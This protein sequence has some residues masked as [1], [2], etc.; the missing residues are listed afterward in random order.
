MRTRQALAMILMAAIPLGAAYGQEAAESA[1]DNP[2]AGQGALV[3]VS[4]AK[5][6]DGYTPA[7]GLENWRHEHDLSGYKPGTYNIIVR[8]RDSAGNTA[9]AGP[10]NI[11]IDPASDLPLTRIAHPMPSMRIGADLNIVGTSKD[12]DAIQYVELSLDDGPWQKAEGGEYW[13]YYLSTATMEDG[14]HALSARAVDANGALGPADLVR[15]HLD[16]TKPAATVGSPPF[17]TLVSGRLALGGEL[18]DANGLGSLAYSLDDGE[19]WKALK[20]SLDKAKTAA[21]FSLAIDTAKMEDGPAVLW[22]KSVDK[23]GSEGVSIFLFF[24][25]NTRPELSILS[26]LPS[27]TVN[28]RF[29]VTGRAYDTVGL[30]SLSWAYGKE[31]GQVE[32]VPG[33]PYFSVDFTAPAQGGK[34]S[35]RFIAEDISGNRSVLDQAYAIDAKADIPRLS[36]AR[37]L[38]NDRIEGALRVHGAARDDDGIAAIEW[39]LDG[40]TVTGIESDGA[41]S[42]TV[43]ELP[44]GKRTLSLRAVDSNGLAGPWLDL[45]LFS[46]A[47]APRLEFAALSDSAGERAFAPG[48]SFSTLEGRASLSARVTAPNTLESLSFAVNDG[49]YLPLKAAKAASPAAI[50]IPLPAS[51]PF[52]VLT[53]RLKAVDAAGK[54][55]VLEAPLYAVNYAKVRIGPTLDF[56]GAEPG[57]PKPIAIGAGRPFVGAFLRPFEGEDIAALSLEPPSALLSASFEGALVRIEAAGEGLSEPTTV[58]VKTTRGHRFSAGPY[59][60]A[61][62][63]L[64]PRLAVLEPAFNSWQRGDFTLKAEASDGDAL[65]RVEYRLQ[66]GPWLA[67]ERSGAA[68][69]A[70]LSVGDAQGP[71]LIELRAVDRAGNE[72]AAASAVMV[73]SVAPKP[74]LILPMAGEPRGGMRLF[75]LRPGEPALSVAGIEL[76]RAGSYEPLAY[77]PVISFA[78]DAGEG[79]LTLRVTDKAGNRAELDLALALAE[80]S[81]LAAQPAA[82]APGEDKLAPAIEL[83]SPQGPQSGPFLLIARVSDAGG[84]ASVSYS[85]GGESGEFERYEGSAYVARLFSFPPKAKVLALTLQAVDGAGNKSQLKL[86]FAYD[87]A[88]DSPVVRVLSPEAGLAVKGGQPFIVYAHDDDELASLS[89]ALD[90]KDYQA[91]GSGPLFMLQPDALAPGKKSAALSAK[92]L[93]GVEA[94]RV[95]VDFTQLGDAPALAISGIQAGKSPLVP[96][97]PGLALA[98]D[99]GTLL[100]GS[101]RAPNGLALLEYAVNGS[102]WQKLNAAA[103]PDSNGAQA[104]GIPLAVSLPFDRVEIALRARDALGAE[105]GERIA[106]Y[107]LAAPRALPGIDAEGLYIADSRVKADGSLLLKPQE[108]LGL[109]WNGRPIAS[110]R[111]EPAW[112]GLE[113]SH[114]GGAISV[115]AL[116][117]GLSPPLTIT[118]STEDGEVYRASPLR[119]FIDAEEPSIRIA[120]PQGAPWLRESLDI[121]GEA[122]DS[123]GLAELA[124]SLDGGLSW[125][126]LDTQAQ[127]GSSMA[128]FKATLPLSGAD[129]PGEL[130]LRARDSAGREGYAAL[131]FVKDTIAPALSLLS[132]LAGE[133][134]NGIIHMSGWAED[135]SELSGV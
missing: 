118:L 69:S 103:K 76:G 122:G 95:S 107:R 68:Y 80:G 19:S 92:D 110:A 126:P 94:A 36:I 61:T 33:N 9:L 11:V 100:L 81:L 96:F 99:A 3:P 84:L 70:K 23:L 77:A 40:G 78:A 28:G 1:A 53:V 59:V 57:S 35:L 72:A 26:P 89:L 114:E 104:F 22:F 15:F 123:N 52:G 82:G 45:P 55:S 109:L 27:D 21:S 98:F 8:A 119:F 90:G 65:E 39:R 127:A 101:V 58:V 128:S 32:L 54:E 7:E 30:R 43:A 125:N 2:P 83:I 116:Q 106:L 44:A 4:P 25:D 91:E 62:D 31:S 131:P 108:R 20:Y 97:K 47:E 63:T 121:S 37:P 73:D 34:L 56:A 17:G 134:V 46:V 13:S 129:G 130:L 6:N 50:T 5:P 79:A 48:L 29:S 87:Q 71:L 93:S 10:F 16:R 124:W 24:V 133:V 67:L 102:A 117:E 18:Y 41:F 115:T 38:A 85:G 88:A 112:P 111:V 64:P 12:D 120:A 135:A 113:L 60:F 66:G 14:L 105:T 74:E 132:P 51:L 49:P 86:S 42:F 75:A